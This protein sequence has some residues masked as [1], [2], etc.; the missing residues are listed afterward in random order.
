MA[1]E[2]ILPYSNFSA[3]TQ[4]NM[5]KAVVVE[6]GNN[7]STEFIDMKKSPMSADAVMDNEVNADTV[8]DAVLPSLELSTLKDTTKAGDVTQLADSK[9]PGILEK[10]K[11]LLM[12]AGA[13]ALAW[14]LFKK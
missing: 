3:Q 8:T 9:M 14:F 6:L 13:G 7:P 4:R 12:L 1:T 10:N 2:I 11:T 5:N